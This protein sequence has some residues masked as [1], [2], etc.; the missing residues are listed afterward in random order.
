MTG[1]ATPGGRTL[2]AA[3]LPE[4]NGVAYREH[5]ALEHLPEKADLGSRL[6][7]LGPWASYLASLCLSVFICIMGE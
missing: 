1:I 3:P 2:E 5:A 7:H 4:A 6:Y